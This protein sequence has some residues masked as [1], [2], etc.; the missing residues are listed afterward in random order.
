MSESSDEDDTN[1]RTGI[2]YR[3]VDVEKLSTTISNLHKC[4][5][6]ELLSRYKQTSH[7]S[8]ISQYI[9]SV[10]FKSLA[11]RPKYFIIV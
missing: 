9:I 8:A 7:L 11:F 5:E 2:G 3:L 6:G 10:I 1:D 4:D